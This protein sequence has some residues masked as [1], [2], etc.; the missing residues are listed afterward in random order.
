MLL[1]EFRFRLRL[2]VRS[3]LA[4]GLLSAAGPQVP[5]QAQGFFDSFFGGFPRERRGSAYQ[6]RAVD[7]SRA[8]AA[9]R[10]ETPPT[11]SIMVF[12]DSMADWL[13]FGLE[14]ALSDS[15]DIG[16][17]RKHRTGSGLIR[18]DLRNDAAEWSQYI[19]EQ[20]AAEKP[21]YVV[22]MVGLHDR[23]Q[24]RERP[25]AQRPAQQPGAADRSAAQPQIAAPEPQPL[26]LGAAHEFRSDKWAELY[27]ERIDE[28]IAAL[29]TANVPVFW[30]GLPALRGARSTSEMGYLNELYKSRA[31]KSGAVFVDVWDGFIDEA[32]RFS[33]QGPDVEGQI[34]R[35]R[36]GDGVHFTRF[37]ARKLAHF[38]EREIRR[39]MQRGSG[40]V[41]L[42]SSD[43]EPAAPAASGGPAARPL[44]GPVLPLTSPPGTGEELLGGANAPSRTG[45]VTATRVLVKGEALDTPAGRGDDFVWPRRGVAA[46]GADPVV[47][48]TTLPIPVMQPPPQK[49]VQAPEVDP[50]PA[51]VAPRRIAR[52]QQPAPPQRERR[53]LFFFPFFR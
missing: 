25:P 39:A 22:M 6:E 33:I 49:T 50:A 32:G 9:R 47:A 45:H 3:L 35:L 28:T 17:A 15:P 23:Q 24:I 43:P 18:F 19:R 36:A 20:I 52:P 12:G 34:R 14:E 40:P 1:K 48:T 46:F 42:P 11:R 2:A 44:A 38:V 5:A 21:A 10:S 37:G 4:A 30:V 16:V 41:A 27:A 31:E 13:G 8:P 51:A 26:R 7:S 29:R 53:Q